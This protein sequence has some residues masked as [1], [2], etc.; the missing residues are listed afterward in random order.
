MGQEPSHLISSKLFCNLINNIENQIRE[1]FKLTY[2]KLSEQEIEEKVRGVK[3]K[4][5]L[6]GDREKYLSDKAEFIVEEAIVGKIG[7]NKPGLLR[8]GVKTDN[9]RTYQHFK[10]ILGD[11]TPNCLGKPLKKTVKSVTLFLETT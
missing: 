5:Y 8:E 1:D 7:F 6:S 2:Y 9:K 10:N 11:V 4:G 3:V